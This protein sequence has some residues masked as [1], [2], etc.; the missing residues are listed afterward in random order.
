MKDLMRR[1]LISQLDN[2]QA[3]KLVSKPPSGWVYAVRSALGMTAKQLAARLGVI[4]QRVSAIEKS[5]PEGSLTIHSLEQVAAALNCKLVYYLVPVEPLEMMLNARAHIIASKIIE[6]SSHSMDLEA[7]PISDK[8]K[9]IQIVEL[10]R[11]ILAK[12]PKDLWVDE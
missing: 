11:E 12:R 6:R 9:R 1:Q 2:I 4:Q 7:Q 8:E 3:L 5:E 10:A